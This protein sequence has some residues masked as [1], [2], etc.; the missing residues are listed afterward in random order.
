MSLPD[1]PKTP[2]DELMT[3]LAAGHETTASAITW[4]LYWIDKFP[5]V[6]QQLL[7]ELQV[8]DGSLDPSVVFNYPI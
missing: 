1:G 8:L 2:R 7:K 4:A 5:T 3:L 6:R